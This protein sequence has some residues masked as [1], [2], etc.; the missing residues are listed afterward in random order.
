[1][2]TIFFMVVSRHIT[3]GRKI[4]KW[5]FGEVNSFPVCLTNADNYRIRN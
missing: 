4:E 1:M 5:Q 3:Q 2:H